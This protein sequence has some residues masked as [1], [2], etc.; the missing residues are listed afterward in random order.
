MLHKL[1]K[2]RADGYF[3]SLHIERHHIVLA[4]TLVTII[5]DV[6]PNVVF[7]DRL[8]DVCCCPFTIEGEIQK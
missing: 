1:G 2:L 7:R 5:N 8:F 4:A 6:L 3:Q